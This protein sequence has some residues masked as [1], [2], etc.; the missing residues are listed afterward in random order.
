MI[1][2]ENPERARWAHLKSSNDG[3]GGGGG[4]DVENC[5]RTDKNIIWST[6]KLVFFSLLAIIDVLL[7]TEFS[8]HVMF[9]SL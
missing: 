2:A 5:L 9:A 7:L 8:S 3:G 6:F 4:E 1:N